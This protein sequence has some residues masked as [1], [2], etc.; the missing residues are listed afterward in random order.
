MAYTLSRS[1]GSGGA[2]CG[3]G[4]CAYLPD[5]LSATISGIVSCGCV[6]AGGDSAVFNTPTALNGTFTS[7]VRVPGLVPNA[8]VWRQQLGEVDLTSHTG[9]DCGGA[10]E[11]GTSYW[12]LFILCLADDSVFLQILG[13]QSGYPASPNDPT[14]NGGFSAPIP[15]FSTPEA[16]GYACG[17]SA[18]LAEG[19]GQIDIP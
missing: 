12:T 8:A 9:E 16:N 13:S 17:G 5:T 4:P 10:G 2:I 6:N 3:C 14:L 1:N 15:T 11:A 19:E 18:Y 7:V